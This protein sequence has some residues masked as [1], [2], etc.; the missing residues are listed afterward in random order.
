MLVAALCC[1]PARSARAA[2]FAMESG[3]LA[4]LSPGLRTAER[5]RV[6]ELLAT[7]PEGASTIELGD[8]R[9]RVKDVSAHGAF[10]S[11]V[12]PEGV[13]FYRFDIDLTPDEREAWLTAAAEWSRV[14]RIRFEAATEDTPDYVWVR[15]AA[16]NYSYVGRIGGPQEMGI[17][18][19]SDR[20]I[21]AHEIG[22]ALGLIHEH[23]RYDRDDF[24]E[25]EW[26][27]IPLLYHPNYERML[28]WNPTGYDFLS[29]MHYRRDTFSRD[30]GDTLRPTS[31]FSEFLDAMGQR[32][33]ISPGDAA[34]MVQRYGANETAAADWQLYE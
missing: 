6:E 25:V 3:D 18:N 27:N 13:L 15:R 30:G 1:L 32:E 8:M 16:F 19:W 22:H 17:R 26:A 7:L 11:N 34:G 31:A 33:R 24:V 12:W 20:W 4:R 28:S 10:L 9:F 5:A 14:A 29:L 23:Q 2:A 21:V